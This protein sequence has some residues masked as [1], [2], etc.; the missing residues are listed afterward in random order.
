MVKCVV[1]L[2]GGGT[3]DDERVSSSSASFRFV[4]S[5]SEALLFSLTSSVNV[6]WGS[7]DLVRPK[8]RSC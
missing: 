6:F 8:K 1:I 7:Q 3:R 4:G 2:Y 5:L